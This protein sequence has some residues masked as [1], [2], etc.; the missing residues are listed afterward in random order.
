M[1]RVDVTGDGYLSREDYE[2]MGIKLTEISKMDE[3]QAEKTRKEFLRVAD[4][5]GLKAGV[6]IPVEE[7]AVKASE[8]L[9]AMT[10]EEKV[11]SV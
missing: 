3:K 7:A 8:S 4:Q 11:K 6:R 2:E 5:I 10:P 9:L 1:L